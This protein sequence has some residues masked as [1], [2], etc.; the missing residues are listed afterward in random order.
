[1]VA[2]ALSHSTRGCHELVGL[3]MGATLLHAYVACGVPGRRGARKNLRQG[4][5][6]GR[7]LVSRALHAKKKTAAF[8][9]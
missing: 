3:D 9:L 4:N 5:F 8:F 1:M 2:V 7:A 6:F